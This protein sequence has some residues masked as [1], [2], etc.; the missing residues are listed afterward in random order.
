MAVEF[1]MSLMEAS[2]SE[3]TCFIIQELTRRPGKEQV[4]V[5]VNFSVLT[6]VKL[7]EKY[8]FKYQEP[9]EEDLWF[10]ISKRG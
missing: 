3:K 10:Y 5:T 1:V 7:R 8:E 6:G 2:K 4:S 9:G